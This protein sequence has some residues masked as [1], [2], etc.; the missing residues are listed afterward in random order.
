MSL[1]AP[2]VNLLNRLIFTQKFQLILVILLLPLVYATWVIYSNNSKDLD[3][4]DH[5]SKGMSVVQMLHPLRIQAAKHRGTSAQWISGNSDAL[6]KVV[7]LEEGMKV[8]LDKAQ[9]VITQY[10]F[11]EA[12]NRHFNTVMGSWDSIKHDTMNKSTSFSDHTLWIEEITKL[13]NELAGESQLVLDSNIDS[14]MLMQLLVFDMPY[15]QETLGQIRGLGAAVATKGSFNSDSFIAVS[16]LYQNISD[17]QGLLNRHYAFIEG[18]N[19]ELAKSVRGLVDSVNES[20]TEFER[21]TKTKLLDPDKPVISGS[22]YFD[23][24][25]QVIT[26]VAA[27]YDKST[28]SYFELLDTNRFDL[29]RHFLLIL[30]I[31]GTMIAAGVYLLSCLK[32]A[33]DVNAHVTQKMAMNMQNGELAGYFESKSNDELGDTI[34]SLSLGFSTLKEVVT[35]VRSHS[36]SLTQSSNS[37]QAVSS[38]VNKSGLDQKQRVEVIVTAA[39]EL[40]ATA[41]EVAVHCDSA[42]KETV[43]AQGKADEGA[44]RSVASASIIR[45][46]AQSIR[47]AGDEISQLAQ[48]ASSISTVIDVIKAIAEQTNLLALNAAIE[49]ARAGEQGRGFAVVADEVRTL[50][51]RTQV[52]TNEIEATIS[53]LQ[54]VAEHAVTAMETACSQADRGEEEA[55]KTGEVLSEIETAVNQVTALIEQVATAG[56]QQAGAAEEIA[57]NIVLVDNAATVLVE[58]AESVS[59]IANEV[60]S[61]SQLLAKTMSHFKV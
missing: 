6:D 43:L 55:V 57:Q 38:D 41:K 58:K 4:F 37:L 8:K 7:I 42:A 24:G 31:F 27:L 21:I 2:G 19:K 39:T 35:E 36:G 59:M 32:V 14:Y 26:K 29:E 49:A 11:S 25:T 52:S 1:L 44:Q 46:L 5:Q 13:I 18:H 61:G 53:S 9:A 16:T 51:N 34:R 33:V 20:I 28:Q 12:I 15:L 23:V 50:A 40:A 47:T 48:Q 3:V 54:L 45:E 30:I 22:D 56:V 17:A 60:G 10:G